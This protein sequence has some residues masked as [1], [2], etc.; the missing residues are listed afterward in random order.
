MHR[1]TT[2]GHV[3]TPAAPFA[4]QFNNSSLDQINRADAIRQIICDPCGH[5]NLATCIRNQQNRA[6]FNTVFIFID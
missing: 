2:L 5:G 3:G 6:A 1:F 4:A